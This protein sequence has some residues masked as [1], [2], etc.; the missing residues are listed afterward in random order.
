MLRVLVTG[1]S[2]GLGFELTNQFLA[3][4]NRVFAGCRTPTSATRLQSL[5]NAYSGQLSILQQDVTDPR[6]VDSSYAY[7][8]RSAGALD[9][10]INNAGTFPGGF[11]NGDSLRDLNRGDLIQTLHVNAVGPIM[12]AKSFLDLL[13]TGDRPKIINI[14]SDAGSLQNKTEGGYYCYCCSKAALN[15]LTRTLA[16]DLRGDGII[17]VAVHP[18]WVQTDMG[19]KNAKLTIPESVRHLIRLINAL[20]QDDTGQFYSYDGS[21]YPW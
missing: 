16:N 19:G 15:M 1:A 17:V 2:R 5:A 18:G 14:S 10:L 21:R 3:Q 11:P 12:V 6:S 7:V 8:K 4:G 20:T 9:L 13:R